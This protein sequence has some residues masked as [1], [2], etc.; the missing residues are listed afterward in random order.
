M[1]D[2]EHRHAGL[3]LEARDQ[4]QDLGLDRDVERRGGL[5]GDHERGL[6]GERHGDHRPLAHAARELVRVVVEPGGGLGHAHQ[7][8][9]AGGLGPGGGPLHAPVPAQD[10]LDL[11]ADGVDRV[12]RGHGLLEDHGD[13][14][15]AD[16]ADLRLA[17]RGQ[18]PAVE[19]DAAPGDPARRLG[20]QAQDRKRRD[21][22]AAA[23]LAHQAEG[24][25]A[26]NREV[27]TV[28]GR[29]RSLPGPELG[30]SGR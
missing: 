27:D 30:L 20:Q 8:E 23:A 19:Q 28:H 10:L 29:D 14:V 25:P 7:P 12:E 13:A 6:A 21:T 3:L 2:E 1:R 15:A 26:R 11:E 22:L 5:V 24:L 16:L 9:H 18:V 4:V 17:Q